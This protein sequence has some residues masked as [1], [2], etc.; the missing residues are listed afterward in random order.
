[1]TSVPIPV[2]AGEDVE[3]PL[4]WGQRKIQRELLAYPDD[5]YLAF[6][7]VAIPVI[8]STVDEIIG[9]LSFVLN[10]S[11]SLRTIYPGADRQRVLGS[12]G[13]ALELTEGGTT[14]SAHADMMSTRF[15]PTDLP[16]RLAL[17]L[18]DGAPQEI[19]AVLTHMAVDGI[20]LEF[21]TSRVADVLAGD[22]SP[23]QAWQPRQLAEAQ[24]SPEG[25][26]RNARTLAWWEA[27]Y[28]SAPAAVF[29][30]PVATPGDPRYV[31]GRMVSFD[32]ATALRTLTHRTRV[33]PSMV[34]LAGLCAIL[35]E[36]S[37][38]PR[39]AVSS[40]S[41]NRSS[42]QTLRMMGT[43]SQDALIVVDTDKPFDDLA[44]Q[45]W[46]SATS[47]YTHST[48]DPDEQQLVRE[49]VD[50]DR[51]SPFLRDTVYNDVSSPSIFGQPTPPHTS[52]IGTTT[53][54]MEPSE[55]M[56]VSAYATVFR[57]DSTFEV[58]L[59]AD[60]AYLPEEVVVDLL[61]AWERVLITA[62]N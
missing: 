34:A 48:V 27:K 52:A 36:H 7:L 42:A 37:G 17:V 4:T 28:R 9:A 41:A 29:P 57:M 6:L 35:G 10:E 62:A 14:E 26:A 51:G 59:W 13:Y 1:M 3:A 2:S 23:W 61:K 19:A 38:Q 22:T 15:G 47:A 56:F 11:E 33:S 30:T 16:V 39:I 50:A 54:T 60:T 32:A 46:E 21:F 5:R 49:K 44:A 45:I 58:S 18:R 20:A 8:G 12:P 31:E 25:L 43:L 53:I 55:F 24:R 40:L